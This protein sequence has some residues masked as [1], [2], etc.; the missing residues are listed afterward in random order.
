MAAVQDEDVERDGH[1]A[2]SAHDKAGLLAGPAQERRAR[3]AAISRRLHTNIL[4][5]FL[6]MATLCYLDRRVCACAR[7]RRAES[8]GIVRA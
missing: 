6:L 5:I 3:G 1:D 8:C 2:A 7:V 4:P